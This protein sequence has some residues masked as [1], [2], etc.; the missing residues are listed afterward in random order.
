M[1]SFARLAGAL[2]I[3]IYTL[4][5][6][7]LATARGEH[8]D[9]AEM[10]RASSVYNIS[11]A[12]ASDP[13]RPHPDPR[14]SH[15]DAQYYREP[16]A[17]PLSE[18]AAHYRS[19]REN[20]SSMEEEL[21]DRLIDRLKDS[22]ID[23][24]PSHSAKMQNA[25]QDLTLEQMRMW[26]APCK[27][28]AFCRK[29]EGCP[30]T[31]IA[32]L[33]GDIV[34]HKSYTDL[35]DQEQIKKN[36]WH[37]L[38]LLEILKTLAGDDPKSSVLSWLLN[39]NAVLKDFYSVLNI[40]LMGMQG[41]P[42]AGFAPGMLLPNPYLGYQPTGSPA[43]LMMAPGLVPGAPNPLFGPMMMPPQCGA[44][45]GMYGAPNPL[46]NPYLGVLGGAAAP[47]AQGD[48]PLATMYMQYNMRNYVQQQQ[49]R[50]LPRGEAEDMQSSQADHDYPF[51]PESGYHKRPKKEDRDK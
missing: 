34:N 18:P 36:F 11:R 13:S 10:T 17:E 8:P 26:C 5:T 50:V 38:W 48:S 30:N 51:I 33:H 25:P 3:H 6:A 28:C 31:I 39:N 22:L 7:V 4:G 46:F 47:G 24:D 9:D 29:G 43:H 49:A 20:I 23:K 35:N 37:L 15:R 1:S 19:R 21:W 12:V 40:T 16:A 41:G 14:A 45:P 32:T 27:A 42:A 44:A 2:L